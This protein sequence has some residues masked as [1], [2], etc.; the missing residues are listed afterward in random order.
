MVLAILSFNIVH[1]GSV[2]L[3][4]ESELP[5]FLPSLKSACGK[6]KEKEYIEMSDRELE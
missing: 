5:G 3:G 1:P 6:R 2:L 4:P